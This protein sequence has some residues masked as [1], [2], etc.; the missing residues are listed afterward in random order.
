MVP[1]I[2]GIIIK[3]KQYQAVYLPVVWE[4][5]PDKKEF[6]NS[7]KMKAGLSP[8]YFSSTFEAYRFETIYIKEE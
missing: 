6:L 8:D 5:L 1:N 7:L 3:D 4:Q 2:D